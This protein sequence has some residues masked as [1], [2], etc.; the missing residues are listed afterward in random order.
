MLE[1]EPVGLDRQFAEPAALGGD[2]SSNG[3]AQQ[4]E[5]VQQIASWRCL[6][7]SSSALARVGNQTLEPCCIDIER[8]RVN[9]DPIR[10]RRLLA[11]RLLNGP[12]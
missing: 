7:A 4:V 9:G 12:D 5:A 11:A 10:A 3:S 8:R 2:H 6:A 1:Q